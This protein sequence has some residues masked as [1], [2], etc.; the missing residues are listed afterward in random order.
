LQSRDLSLSM[1]LLGPGGSRPRSEAVLCRDGACR[2]PALCLGPG[3]VEPHPTEKPLSRSRCSAR[4]VT[5]RCLVA[6]ETQCSVDRRVVGSAYSRYRT[7]TPTR[8]LRC[9]VLIPR[10]CTP[11]Q[12]TE[13]ETCCMEPHRGLSSTSERCCCAGLGWGQ[14]SRSSAGT[15]DLDAGT[16]LLG[17]KGTCSPPPWG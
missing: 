17:R 13:R 9:S 11:D 8:S 10:R 5:R 3:V 15:G 12:A 6:T 4:P 2:V 16:F 1:S 7:P 14:P